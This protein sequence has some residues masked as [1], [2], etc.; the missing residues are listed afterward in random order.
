MIGID[1]LDHSCTGRNGAFAFGWK[2]WAAFDAFA[3]SSGRRTLEEAGGLACGGASLAARHTAPSDRVPCH[4]Q[5]SGACHASSD[6]AFGSPYDAWGAAG[7]PADPG[8]VS[9]AAPIAHRGPAF[10]QPAYAAASDWGASWGRDSRFGPSSAFVKG[11]P[12]LGRQYME[13]IV[14][15]GSFVGAAASFAA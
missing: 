7:S 11:L 9:A 3:H 13:D 5:C 15:C 12:C 4:T 10:E 8:Q 1:G 2:N 14:P 6:P